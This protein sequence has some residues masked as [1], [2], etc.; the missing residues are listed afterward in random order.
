MPHRPTLPDYK[1]FS[2]HHP[3]FLKP[4]RQALAY[5]LARALL[6]LANRL[7]VPRLQWLGRTLGQVV[8]SV[9]KRERRLC[10][11]QLALALPELDATARRRL[12]RA[13]L[14][15]QGMTLMETLAMPRLRREGAH[16]LSL[17]GDQALAALHAAGRGAILV[18]AH[19]ANWELLLIALERLRI[20]GLAVL[21]TLTNPRIN[22]LIGGIRRFE[23]MDVA[24]RGSQSSPRQLLTSLKRGEVLIL[25][26]DVDIDAQ[27]V[28]VDFFGIPAHTPRGAASLALKLG[29]PLM[30]YFDARQP[31]GTHLLRFREVPVTEAI[32]AAPDPVQ[33][34]TQAISDQTEAHI[35]AH[36]E[37]WAWNHPRWKRRPARRG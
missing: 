24:E 18:T 21:S 4:L 33:A 11:V 37:Q 5:L 1:A 3:A 25:A 15:H 23:Y 10:D 20:H 31:D 27:G 19:V 30:T 12:G 36:P 34:L 29:S 9:S 14:Q 17:E 13:C 16:W 2:I 35:R 8:Y 7:S 32:R 28:F 6:A 26:N 22:K